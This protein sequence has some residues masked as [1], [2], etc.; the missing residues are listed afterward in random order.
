MVLA[1]RMPFNENLPI[2]TIGQSAVAYLLN[3]QHALM[4]FKGAWNP[5]RTDKTFQYQLTAGIFW[6]PQE[7]ITFNSSDAHPD[8]VAAVYRVMYG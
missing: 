5:K 8:M 6:S 4:A 7:G 2:E 3:I 1:E